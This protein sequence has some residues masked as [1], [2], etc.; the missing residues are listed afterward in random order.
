MN[1]LLLQKYHTENTW[2]KQQVKRTEKEIWS[3][4]PFSKN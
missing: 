2:Y 4:A 3:A 1:K